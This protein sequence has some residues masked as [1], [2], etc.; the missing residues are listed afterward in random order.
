MTQAGQDDRKALPGQIGRIVGAALIAGAAAFAGFQVYSGR[1][2][3]PRAHLAPV[4]VG[5]TTIARG[6]A[7]AGGAAAIRV[8][9]GEASPPT[10]SDLEQGDTNDTDA[11]DGAPATRVVIPTRLPAFSLGDRDGKATPIS[12]WDGKSLVINFWATW[13]APCRREIPLLES[14][15]SE[16]GGRNVEI[17]GI[18][19]DYREKVAVFARQL[20]IPYPLLVGEQDALDVAARFGVDSPVFPFTVFTDRRGDIVALVVGELHR[21]QADLILDMVQRLNSDQVKLPE[22]RRSIAAGLQ[23]LSPAHPG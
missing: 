17:V 23:A 20:K 19:V 11:M 10:P 7:T 15:Y 13:C 21:P 8:P 2:P 18:A 16:W 6:T 3:I 4:S 12:A 14:L 22:A 1:A 9:A 5:D